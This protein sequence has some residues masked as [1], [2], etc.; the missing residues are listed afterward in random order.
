M[1]VGSPTSQTMTRRSTRVRARIPILITSLD[2]A[3]PCSLLCET[4]IVNAHGCAAKVPQPL[5]IGMPVR[6]RVSPPPANKAGDP[7]PRDSREATARIV[8]CQPI[9]GNQPSWVAGI[10]L[11]KP[12]NLWGLTPSPEDWKRFDAGA[13]EFKAGAPAGRPAIELKMPVWPLASPSAQAALPARASEEEIKKQLAAQQETTADL[14]NRLATLLASVPGVVREQLA[15][16]QQETVAQ[17]RKQLSAML[18]QS[19]QQQSPAQAEAMARLQE[20]LAALESLPSAVREQLAE[21]RASLASIA[22]T[23]PKQLADTQQETLAQVRKQLS[24]MLAESVQQQSPG[25]RDAIAGLQQ[26]LSSLA[27]V[28]EEV[29]QQLSDAQQQTQAQIREQLSA[30]LTGFLKPFQEELAVCRKKAEDAQQ[31]RATVAEQFEQLPWQIQQHA[32]AAFRPLQQRARTELERIIAEAR[33]QDERKP[34]QR[35]A[36]QSSAQVLQ[37]EHEQARGTLESSMR[38]LPERMQGPIAAAVED[39]LARGGA[40]ISAAL[41]RELEA[42]HARGRMVADELRG[43]AD[44]LRSEREATSAQLVALG[45]KREE[46]QLWLAEQQAVY[47]KQANRQFEQLTDQ[48]AAYTNEVRQKLEQLATELAT[49]SAAALEKQIRSDV[50]NQAER[51]EADLNQRLGPMLD[52]A[53]DLRQE[54][55]SLLGTLQKESERCQTQARALLEEKDSVDDWIKERAADFQKMFHDAL[56][57]T[58]GQIK[59][60]LQMAV[61]M[62]EQP[63]E[64]LRDQAAQQLQEQSGRQARHLREYADEASERLRGL[65]R[66]IETAVRESLRTQAAE[67][68]ATCGREIAQL[69]QRS[70]EEWRSALASNLESIAN[71][72]GQK[73]PGGEG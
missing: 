38:S 32:Q 35:Q 27:S 51:A 6:L 20:R 59:G 34:A 25:E 24:A 53:S 18:A 67:T 46:L 11:G 66:E 36:L 39:A 13:T 68:S 40:E 48:Q 26:R 57:E 31:I 2:P 28:P 15:E 65:Q 17:V 63:V 73:L 1:T 33:S 21:T 72:L 42:G 61:E 30:A 54:V 69:A 22:E 45:A 9:G 10:E 60:R 55:L 56:V 23:V 52:R 70:V 62:M 58:T 4:L 7:A 14:E 44:L 49:R 8:L 16:S 50:E 3:I 64:K 29:R 5:E 71:L 37:K 47:A 41:A 12:G 43:A 19:V